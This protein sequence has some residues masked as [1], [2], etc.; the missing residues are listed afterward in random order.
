MALRKYGRN[1]CVVHCNTKGVTK[2]IH[3]YSIDKYGE[4]GAYNRA[5]KMHQAIM[6][7]KYGTPRRR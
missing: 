3:C 2:T 5:L 6:V 7:S 4:K 1:W